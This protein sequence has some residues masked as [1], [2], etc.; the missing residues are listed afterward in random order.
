MREMT[1][2]EL[3]KNPNYVLVD[4]RTAPMFVQGH[5]PGSHS[6]PFQRG[7]MGELLQQQKVPT[8]AT[9]VVLA[10]NKVI[11]EQTAK[12]LQEAGYRVEGY[13]TNFLAAWQEAGDSLT[14]VPTID[15]PELPT[16][17]DAHPEYEVIDVR[18]P[19][20][21]ARGIIA[22]AYTIDLG[23]LSEEVSNLDPNKT[24]VTICAA[25][26]RST[27]AAAYLTSLGFKK[28]VNIRG[29]MQDWYTLGH[30]VATPE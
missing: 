19:D 30:P 24:Y 2:A 28:L 1:V 15:L 10:M 12:E 13:T 7:G 20:E 4:T 3:K 22:G 17:L 8:T 14:T 5:I 26:G 16:T 29:G 9:V 18:R 23:S 21:H 25:G 6:L 11:G 27:T